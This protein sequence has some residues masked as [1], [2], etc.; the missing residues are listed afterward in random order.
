M[1]V[2]VRDEDDRLFVYT[3]GAD[4]VILPRL[5]E[6]IKNLLYWFLELKK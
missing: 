4:S 1:S 5:S 3:K 2:I 6:V